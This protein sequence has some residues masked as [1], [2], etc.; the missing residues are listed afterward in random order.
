MAAVN[1]MENRRG[2]KVVSTMTAVDMPLKAIAAEDH[3]SLALAAEAARE[4][5]MR[6]VAASTTSNR[7]RIIRRERS[8]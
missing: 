7:W 5:D 1:A 8:I 2:R 4:M 3:R 6:D